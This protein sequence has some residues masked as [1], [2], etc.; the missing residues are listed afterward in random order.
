VA[1]GTIPEEYLGFSIGWKE[2]YAIVAGISALVQ[3]HGVHIVRGKR[4]DFVLD[5]LGDVYI[6]KSGGSTVESI[7]HLMEVFFWQQVQLQFYSGLATWISTH[8]NVFLDAYT[9]MPPSIDA[10]LSGV[11]FELLDLKWGPLEVDVMATDATAKCARFFSR[12]CV[13][14]S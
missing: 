2:L 14:A 5:N 11:I 10:A 1:A 12:I 9:R 3:M 4:L 13:P 8:A 7:N 6:L